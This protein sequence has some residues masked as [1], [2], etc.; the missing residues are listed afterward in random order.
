MSFTESDLPLIVEENRNRLLSIANDWERVTL[1]DIVEVLNGFAF[2]SSFFNQS[3][4]FPI[5][6]I[7]NV[8]DGWSDTYYSGPFDEPYRVRRGDLLV[9]MDGDFHCARW[10]SEDALLNQRV[11]KLTP[12]ER[13]YDSSFLLYVIPG[14]LSAIHER[15]HAITVKH[16]SSRTLQRVPLPLPPLVEQRAIVAKIESLFSE[17]DQGVAQLEAVRTQ[18][19]RYR[20]S[21][22]KA[23]FEGRL[24]AAWRD[25]RRREAEANGEPLPTADDLL[26]RIR[27][28]REAAHA[29]RLAE[30][31]LAVAAWEEA[32]GKASGIK[33]P[34]RPAAPKDPPPLTPEELA[35]LPELPE[36]WVWTSIEALLS[37]GQ[38]AMKTGPFGTALS[39]SE[40]RESGVPVLGIENIGEGMFLPDNKIFV[41]ATKGRSLSAY[42]VEAGDIIVSRSGTVG[43]LCVV[44]EVHDGSLISTNL[45]RIR[46]Q[47]NGVSPHFFV[48]LFQTGSIVKQQ[49]VEL[50]K[51]SSRA[52][53]N[54]GILKSL[55]LPLAP[56]HE[57]ATLL[58]EI[59][60]Q[61]SV[62]D[63]VE[64]TIAS[65]LQQAEALRQSILKRAFEGRLLSEAELAAV[66]ADPAYEPADQLLARIRESN[67]SAAPMKK[68]RRKP[69][70]KANA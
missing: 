20:Q 47:P 28:E 68:T 22:L 4:G 12:D 14:Y 59:D 55:A 13:F 54:Q 25:K 48:Y 66:R 6:R 60:A 7:R 8:L 30:W 58:S 69:T 44:P 40:H 1:G 43:E 31:E 24:T 52:F 3:D 32:G 29:A 19:G 62:V 38:E 34:R 5:V 16:L 23:A 15:T 50:C 53:L 65:A 33:K 70:T 51:G 39:K 11:C 35:D 26:A 36:G 2:K 45:V 67:P 63:E 42:A 64:R 18:L 56:E 37:P 10:R 49:V 27:T 17:L 9:G 21:V 57:L 61:F 41:T 46:L